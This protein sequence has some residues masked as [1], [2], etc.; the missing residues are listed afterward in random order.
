M[1]S[2]LLFIVSTFCFTSSLHGN[3]ILLTRKLSAI[4]LSLN[5][6]NYIFVKN[7]KQNIVFK[8]PTPY[9]YIEMNHLNLR[10][11]F[12]SSLQILKPVNIMF[13]GFI[14][15]CTH[16][17]RKEIINL[18]SSHNL[19]KLVPESKANWRKRPSTITAL[20]VMTARNPE[21]SF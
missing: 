20:L 6:L 12:K 17:H 9:Y 1:K 13:C 14:G 3:I 18:Q 5:I 15:T 4:I 10:L 11:L 8:Q 7:L 16:S 19:N 2:A 21:G